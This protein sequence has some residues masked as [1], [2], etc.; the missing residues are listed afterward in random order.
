MALPA[1]GE[2][3]VNIMMQYTLEALN[4]ALRSISLPITIMVWSDADGLDRLKVAGSDQVIFKLLSVPGPD[5]AFESMSN[6]HRE[7]MAVAG[8]RDRVLL[9]TAD[10]VVSREVLATCERQ[11]S[12]GKK[13]VCCAPPRA[14]ED[15]GCPVGADG[16][17][18]MEW[19]WQNRHPMTCECTWPEGRSYDVWRMY[20][21]REGEVAARVF[22][23]HP[24]ACVPAGRRLHFRPTIDVNLCSNFTQ[25][26]TYMITTPEEGAV[27]ELSPRD[28]EFIR[29]TTM[30]ERMT[31]IQHSC[32]PLIRATNPRHR[33]FFEKRIVIRGAGGDCGDGE[34]VGR[35]LG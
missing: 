28:K 8:P 22:L 26:E 3:C 24:L 13:L 27:A 6:C 2:R 30:R 33:M 20:F 9:L 1:W 19:A 35:V 34:V 14:L 11:L 12:G 32:P 15:A 10:M 18:L 16:R 4:V 17:G 25:S 29:T 31:S 21:E 7:A 23:P 5:G